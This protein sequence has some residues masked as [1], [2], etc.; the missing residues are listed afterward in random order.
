M[1]IGIFAESIKRLYADGKI[2]KEKIMK[3]KKD[4]KLTIEEMNYILE[5]H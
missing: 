3:L 2:E 1:V 5:A 4:G